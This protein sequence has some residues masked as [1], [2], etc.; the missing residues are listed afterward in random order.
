VRAILHVDLDAFFV[1]VELLRRPELRGKPVVVGGRGDPRTRGVVS[2]ASY[3]ARGFGV[4]AGMPLR[5]VARMCPEAVFLPVDFSAIRPMSERF[6][7]LL[8]SVSPLVE[9]WGLDEAFVEVTALER[10][11]AEV[12]AEIQR[13]V[14]D[15]LGLACSVG[16]STN[17]LLAKIASDLA[18]PG[19][20]RGVT[21]D[22]VPAVVWP[23][24][25]TALV[26]IGPKTAQRLAPLGI[27]TVGDLARADPTALEG[28]LG[29][30]WAAWL[31]RSARGLDESPINNEPWERRSLSLEHTFD[32]D[33]GDADA[34]RAK[35]RE[36][37]GEVAAHLREEGFLAQ[38]VAVKVRLS[39]FDTYQ[40]QKK[41]AAPSADA[42]VLFAAALACFERVEL[43]RKVRL[44]GLRASGLVAS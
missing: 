12:A 27:T 26:G 10:P 40:R 33:V 16:W 25:P 7:A 15:E 8:R 13:R 38:T 2:S 30:R 28:A 14:R 11:A 32:V 24:K 18:K 31:Q 35:L 43:S 21:M 39:N 44:L 17:K 23:L 5:R 42:D 20:I 29:A 41:L 19:G 3:E 34:L 9:S 36:M 1:A 6:H 4:K 37:A 22:D